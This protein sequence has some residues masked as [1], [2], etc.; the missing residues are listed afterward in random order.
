MGVGFAGELLMRRTQPPE[1]LRGNSM[2][3]WL[4]LALS[5]FFAVV[6]VAQKAEDKRLRASY[7]TLRDILGMPDKGIPRDLL[8][9]AECVIVV[10]SMKKAAFIVGASYGRGVMTCRSGENFR[11]PW[12]APAFFALEGASFG[13]QA[14]GEATDYVILVMN[15]KGAKSVM[16]SKVKLGGDASVAAGPVGR[17]TSAETDIVMNAEMLA[18]SRAKGV[19]AGVSLEGSTIRS[20]DSANKNLYGKEVNAK[21]II[22]QKEEKT[23]DAG[24]QLIALLDKTSPKHL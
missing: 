4:A 13:L 12:S 11:G 10:P 5:M 15:E 24:K 3:R 6:A 14:G 18:W 7:E 19:F 1:R 22:I 21:Q 9:K 2:K 17:T 16:A 23:P 20:D 8:N